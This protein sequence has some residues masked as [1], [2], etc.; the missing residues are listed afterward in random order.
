MSRRQH[1]EEDLR[2]WFISVAKA[3]QET[4][5]EVNHELSKRVLQVQIEPS[6]V[7]FT[8]E[9]YQYRCYENASQVSLACEVDFVL[10]CV[11][12]DS[13]SSEPFLHAW[14]ADGEIYFDLTREHHPFQ[15]ATY[16]SFKAMRATPKATFRLFNDNEI[17]L[18]HRHL[19]RTFLA[20]TKGEG[21]E[22][23]TV[24]NVQQDIL[25]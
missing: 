4:G 7:D 25:L 19:L 12:T 9:I 21:P 14:N 11:V 17:N 2:E 20:T 16:Y 6:P 3:S 24:P 18:L 8:S 1:V 13:S 10:G 15:G 22:G 5:R 23:I